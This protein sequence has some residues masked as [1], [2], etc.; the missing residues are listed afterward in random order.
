MVNYH[1][2]YTYSH[3]T[4]EP[5]MKLNTN[6]KYHEDGTVTFWS[7]YEQRWINHAQ[8]VPD[9]EL[10]AMPTDEREEVKAFLRAQNIDE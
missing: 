6:T 2:H 1:I 9:R 4:Q 3:T 10:A 5:T 7:V 8:R